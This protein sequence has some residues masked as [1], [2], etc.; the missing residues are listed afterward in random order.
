MKFPIS[1]SLSSYK[2]NVLIKTQKHGL[3]VKFSVFQAECTGS[4]PA[5]PNFF[6]FFPKPFFTAN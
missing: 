5:C 1:L 4:N 2:R 6:R 3:L